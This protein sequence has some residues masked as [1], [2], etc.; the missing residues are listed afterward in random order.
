MFLLFDVGGTKIRVAAANHSGFV[1]EV[2]TAPTPVDFNRGLEHIIDTAHALC[3]GEKII[4]VV[5]GVAGAL[6]RG[7]NM[8]V[9][10]SNI[11]SWIGRPI[12]ELLG[13]SLDAPVYLE[14]DSAL[15]G[16]GEAVS[17]AG[18][19]HYIVGYMTVS[20]GV[21]GARITNKKIDPY[22]FGFQPGYQ[23]VDADGSLC[24]RCTK[25][26]LGAHVSGRGIEAHY[27][28]KP[29]DI[30]DPVIWEGIACALAV[31]LTNTI[32]H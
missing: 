29:E 7:R 6:N 20:T 24:T 25:R 9:S 4:A 16:L 21:G 15:A 11:M 5:G 3:A 27:G 26:H 10:G 23:I 30:T 28:K 2:V 13:V 18:K 19:D 8:L 22:V 12:K 31:G 1:G 17:G 32:V 14:N